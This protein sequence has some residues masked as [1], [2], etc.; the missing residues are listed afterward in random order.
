[1]V[2][3]QVAR[4]GERANFLQPGYNGRFTS[5]CLLC[6]HPPGRVDMV[7]LILVKKASVCLC[8]TFTNTHIHV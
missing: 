5:V 4:R 7:Q 2:V 3:F 8:L 6:A 1:M